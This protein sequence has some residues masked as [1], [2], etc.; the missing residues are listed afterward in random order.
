MQYLPY[1]GRCPYDNTTVDCTEEGWAGQVWFCQNGHEWKDYRDI[2]EPD[3]CEGSLKYGINQDLRH[4]ICQWCGQ[5]VEHVPFFHFE[6]AGLMKFHEMIQPPTCGLEMGEW[7]H[8]SEHREM[9]GVECDGC[10]KSFEQGQ[11]GEFV[12]DRLSRLGYKIHRDC[13]TKLVQNVERRS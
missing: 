8:V 11:I 2:L 12:V 7:F 1:E 3:R 10:Y 9:I 6:Y 13:W 4:S 5:I